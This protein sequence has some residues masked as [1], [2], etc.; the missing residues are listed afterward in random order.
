MAVA[1]TSSGIDVF[2][3]GYPMTTGER[4][5]FE[6][7]MRFELQE[8][9]LEGYVTRSFFYSPPGFKK[10]PSYELDM[11]APA[12]LS[13]GPFVKRP[14]TNLMGV[15]Y[16]SF[17]SYTIAQETRI[18]HETGDATP[19]VRRV[20]PFGLATYVEAF[21]ALSGAATDG[22][23]LRDLLPHPQTDEPGSD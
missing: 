8:R 23:P 16:G 15:V 17:D 12:G 20:V 5:D 13:G 21:G 18:D 6:G 14:G 19:E 1:D 3:Y 22:K 10:T 7:R 2:T 4:T 11:L 9:Y